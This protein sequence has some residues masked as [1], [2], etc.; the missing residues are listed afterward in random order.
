[1]DRMTFG[2]SNYGFQIGGN[3]G[4]VNANFYVD[5]GRSSEP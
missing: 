4:T 3:S 1:M 2:D 5:T